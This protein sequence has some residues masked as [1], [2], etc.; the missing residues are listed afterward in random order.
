MFYEK[1]TN[2]STNFEMIEGKMYD[3]KRT[4]EYSKQSYTAYKPKEVGTFAITKDGELI[5]E[6]KIPTLKQ[7]QL[8]LNL[9]EGY[10]PNWV[11]K[12]S[13]NWENVLKWIYTSKDGYKSTSD[14]NVI[15]ERGA[16]KE[17]GY[18]NHNYYKNP[19]KVEACKYAGK[20]YIRKIVGNQDQDAWGVQN[21]YWGMRFEKYVVKQEPGIKATYQVLKG[22]IGGTKVL[23]CAEVDAVRKDGM[24]VEVKTCF[25]DR[26]ADKLLKIWLQSYLGKVDIL[27]FGWKEKS[28]SVHQN[29]KE[30]LMD[31][32]PG[33]K[34][35]V[36]DANAMIGFIGEIIDWIYGAL[37][38]GNKTWLVEYKG[39]GP[40]SLKCGGEE[41]L[42][43][44]Y[45]KFVDGG[46]A[47]ASGATEDD[48]VYQFDKLSLK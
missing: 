46:A 23:M 28:G 20:V 45:K 10:D 6:A 15:A 24:T 11:D 29:P 40:I 32:I 12:Y 19:W 48:T 37:P 43:G 44:W 14:V 39:F 36:K 17:I 26:L 1:F 42:P 47:A 27:F 38:N 31:K 34:L 21:T 9:N 2:P 4:S 8:P 5:N 18:T 30:L 13:S 7:F 22:E 35:R 16:L 41:F 25:E 3:I 33:S